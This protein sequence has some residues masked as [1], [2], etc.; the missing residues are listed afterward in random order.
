MENIETSPGK[1]KGS[2]IVTRSVTRQMV[3][4]RTLELAMLDGRN[5]LQIKQVDYERA[6]R[7]LTGESDFDRQQEI[8]DFPEY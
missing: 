6:K 7:E 8:F 2:V 1:G 5:N 4:D 3:H